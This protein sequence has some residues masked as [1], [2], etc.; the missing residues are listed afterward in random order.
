MPLNEFLNISDGPKIS[1]Y[2]TLN[3]IQNEKKKRLNFIAPD[4]KSYPLSNI[5]YSVLL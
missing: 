4:P 1:K 2:F 3:G 5:L